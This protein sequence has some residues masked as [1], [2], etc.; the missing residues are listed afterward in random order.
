M[1][2]PRSLSE[3]CLVI[4]LAFLGHG[5]CFG[6]SWEDAEVVDIGPA[7]LRGITGPLRWSPNGQYLAYYVDDYLAVYDTTDGTKRVHKIE[8]FIKFF[9]WISGNEIAVG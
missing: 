9:E 4:L 1:D 2:K 3:V 5:V 6:G 8:P 7:R